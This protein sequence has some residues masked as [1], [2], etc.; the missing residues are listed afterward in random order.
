MWTLS[1][2]NFSPHQLHLCILCDI[3]YTCICYRLEI[4]HTERELICHW[5]FTTEL[6][7]ITPMFLKVLL[8]G[9]DTWAQYALQS[10]RISS[11]LHTAYKEC[12]WLVT[13]ELVCWRSSLSLFL[14]LLAHWADNGT[15][16]AINLS[17]MMAGYGWFS[18]LFSL[19]M[20]ERKR[21]ERLCW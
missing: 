11:G 16:E 2:V 18:L 8:F 13:G 19:W 1:P 12:V 14:C 20:E 15:K 3:H 10:Y 4:K 21:K 17:P 6:L 5:T 9:A 7:L